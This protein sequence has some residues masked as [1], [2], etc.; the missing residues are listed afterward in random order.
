M[1]IIIPGVPIPQARMRHVKKGNFVTT[2]DPNA[3]EKTLLRQLLESSRVV[4][5]IN[6]PRVSFLFHMPIPASIPKKLR[7][8][9]ES[10]K[11]KHDK[12]PDVDNLIKLYFDVLDGI[13]LN[14]DQKASLGPSVKVYHPEPKTL[15]WIH[16]TS[17]IVQPWELDIAF[18]GVEELDIPCFCE[19]DYPYGSESLWTQ[20]RSL[21]DRNYTPVQTIPALP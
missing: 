12:K 9:Y 11:L 14:G 3:K 1:K 13:V 2:Y 15:I 8:L 16:E 20:V 7:P 19:Q 5:E 6:F 4:N 18:V 21:F 10:G 17:E